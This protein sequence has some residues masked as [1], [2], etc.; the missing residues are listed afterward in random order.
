METNRYLEEAKKYVMTYDY[1][2]H[3]IFSHGKGTIE[4]N[5]KAAV[6]RGLKAIAITDHGPGHL[7]Y[8]IKRADIPK[9]RQEI[10]RLRKIYP[11]DIYLGVEANVVSTGNGLDVSKEEFK[12]YDFVIC[13]YHYGVKDGY[14]LKN[15]FKVKKDEM[16]MVNTAMV[17]NAIYENDIK[18]LTHP[19]DKAPFDILAIAKACQDRGTLM[20]ISTHHSHLNLEELKL[21]RN[22]DNKFILSSDAHRPGKVGDYLDGLA[23]ALEAGI[24]PERIVNIK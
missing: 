6:E 21:L 19:G 4:D 15:W 22:T 13:G 16:R 11:I 18:I 12:D 1:H 3:T 10:E 5:V 17:I 23:R 9:M 14:C 8:G 7:T 2:T 24:D 20:E